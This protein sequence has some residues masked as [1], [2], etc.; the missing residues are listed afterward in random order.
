MTCNYVTLRGDD[1]DLTPAVC[2]HSC[3][4]DYCVQHQRM[5]D[6]VDELDHALLEMF[7]EIRNNRGDRITCK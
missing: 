2:G 6:P 4:G 3:H 5:L 1:D 7:R